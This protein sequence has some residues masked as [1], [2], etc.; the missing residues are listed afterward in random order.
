MNTPAIPNTDLHPSM[1]CFGT[2]NIGVNNTESEAH[3]L[4][5]AFVA[6]GGNFIDTARVYSNWIPGESN[7][8]ERIIGDWLVKRRDRDRLIIATKGGHFELE[9]KIPRLSTREL[10]IDLAGSLGKLQTDCIDLYWLHRDDPNR[11][12]AELLETLHTF[13]QAGKIRHYACS[14]W[15][16][17]RIRQANAYAR[18]KGYTGFVANQMRWSIG[19]PNMRPSSDPTMFAMDE[20]TYD[21]HV[22]TGLAAIPYSSQAGGFFTKLSADPD[23]KSGYATSANRALHLS[24]Q[25]LSRD[26]NLTIS[27]IV[28]AYLWSHPFPVIPIIG[29]RNIEQLED[30]LKAVGHR[31]PDDVVKQL[32]D[33]HNLPFVQE[34]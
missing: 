27:Q 21:F 32:T 16:P 15:H 33:K 29:C 25:A 18:E 24:L 22:Q 19:S 2:A 7:R 20:P 8:S 1:L 34:R 13:Q 26:L 4:L 12:V 11:S 5:D 3:A 23:I 14:N 31:L 17:D 30:S 10:E 6:H 28:L 9:D